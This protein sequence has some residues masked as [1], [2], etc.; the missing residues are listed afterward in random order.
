M[1]W[2]GSFVRR[3]GEC[4]EGEWNIFGFGEGVAVLSVTSD[5]FS[6]SRNISG[7]LSLSD[8]NEWEKAGSVNSLCS[9]SAGGDVWQ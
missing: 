4:G 5:S 3:S 6:L 8:N 9:L 2:G 7:V 1:N